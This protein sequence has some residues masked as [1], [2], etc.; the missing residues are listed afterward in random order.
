MTLTARTASLLATLGVARLG[1]ARP[2]VATLGVATLGVDGDRLKGN[3]AV[4]SPLTGET[5]AH[6]ADTDRAEVMEVVTRAD[7]AFA[8]WRAVPAPRRGVT[9]PAR[10]T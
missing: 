10:A 2:G 3:R 5:I 7:A 1:V 4:R 8:Q 6:V 9:L